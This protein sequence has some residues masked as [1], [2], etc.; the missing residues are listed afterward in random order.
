MKKAGSYSKA[1]HG[2]RLVQLLMVGVL[3]RGFYIVVTEVK[4]ISKESCRQLKNAA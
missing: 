4:T 1:H 3:F 2:G